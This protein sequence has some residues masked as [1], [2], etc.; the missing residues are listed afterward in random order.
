MTKKIVIISSTPRRGGNSEMLC[1]EFQRGVVY[2]TGAWNAGDISKS[3]AISEA[4][5]L[6]KQA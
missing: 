4:F 3:S 5:K 6:G 2:G 1:E